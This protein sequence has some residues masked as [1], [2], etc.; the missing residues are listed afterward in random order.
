MAI[1]IK[2]TGLDKAIKMFDKLG[3]TILSDKLL[4]YIAEK[5]IDEINKIAKEKL[6][7]SENYIA[8]NEYEKIDKG[9][10]IYNNIQSEDGIYISLI[11]EYGSGIYKEGAD[12]HHTS[13]YESSGGTYWLVPV[14]NSNSLANTNY[15]IINIKGVEYYRVS[16]QQ[17]KHI[18][19][20]AAKII[21]RN[22]SK[23]V[24]QYIESEMK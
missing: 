2:S 6:Q 14:E 10:V 17:P 19:T 7:T 13:T 24:A 16:A 23:W 9:V 18:Y 1:T 8:N 21:R 5:A 3:K 11:I 4:D 12:F 15:P 22:V 20:D